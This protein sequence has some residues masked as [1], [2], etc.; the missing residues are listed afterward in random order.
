MW[1]RVTKVIGG[2]K[3]VASRVTLGREGC[4]GYMGGGGVPVISHKDLS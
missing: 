2:I 1:K 3:L 4:L